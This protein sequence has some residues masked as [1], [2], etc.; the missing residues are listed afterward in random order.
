MVSIAARPVPGESHS[1]HVR[2]QVFAGP[3]EDR[4]ALCGVLTMRPDEAE[5]LIDTLAHAP[6][7]AALAAEL[8]DAVRTANAAEH[9][10]VT[11]AALSAMVVHR[12]P[13]VALT[14]PET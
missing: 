8:V 6:A 10:G 3:D 7:L 4:R 14:Y 2:V 11:L 12:L 5:A 9:T 13:G 1:G